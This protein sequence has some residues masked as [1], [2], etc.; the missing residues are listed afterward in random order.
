[1][2]TMNPELKVLHSYLMKIHEYM[3]THHYNNG[4]R[5]SS[6]LVRKIQEEMDIQHGL[7]C[8]ESINALLIEQAALV[9]T[10]RNH[11]SVTNNITH[12]NHNTHNTHTINNNIIMDPSMLMN[13]M[14][15][16]FNK[17]IQ[18][19]GGN[20]IQLSDLNVPALPPITKDTLHNNMEILAAHMHDATKQRNNGAFPQ[21]AIEEIKQELVVYEKSTV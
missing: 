1:M 7:S 8:I 12:N 14:L 15:Q 4:K 16:T 3:D 19:R 17:S 18:Q 11:P 2:P 10:M 13:G 6:G 20:P 21:D 5:A 9:D